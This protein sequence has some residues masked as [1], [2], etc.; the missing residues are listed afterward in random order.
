VRFFS[1]GIVPRNESSAA[2]TNVFWPIATGRRLSRSQRLLISDAPPR[3]ATAPAAAARSK[4]RIVRNASLRPR[5][6]RAL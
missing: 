2:Y 1:A 4:S 6:F 3:L 5:C